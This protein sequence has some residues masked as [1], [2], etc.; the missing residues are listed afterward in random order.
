MRTILALGLMLFGL[1]GCGNE[2]TTVSDLPATVW[3]RVGDEVRLT[4]P[5]LGLRLEA[6]VQDSR[7]PVDVTCV[8]AGSVTVRLAVMRP[9]Q[10]DSEILLDSDRTDSSTGLVLRIDQVKPAPR[11]GVVI[12]PGEYR[13]SLEIAPQIA[14]TGI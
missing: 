14:P 11:A 3:L 7:C 10:P 12:A 5:A 2:V 9:G 4:S 13:V 8:Q 1:A 6:I